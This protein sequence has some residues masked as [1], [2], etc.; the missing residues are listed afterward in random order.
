MLDRYTDR[1]DSHFQNRKY[2]IL[3]NLF[4]AV[5]LSFYYVESK[6][7]ETSNYNDSQPV[8]LNDEVVELNH[9]SFIYT[10]S[11]PLMSLSETLKCR[12]VR[13][14]LRYHEPNPDKYSE[15][16]VHHLLFT[17]YPFRNEDNLK[18]DGRYFAKLQRSGVLDI[19]DLNDKN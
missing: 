13:A 4:F 5:F 10:K 7:N 19:I 2:A 12:T 9:K 3:E 14:I 15:K 11:V 17:F 8:V 6:I 18:L 1:P 16:Y